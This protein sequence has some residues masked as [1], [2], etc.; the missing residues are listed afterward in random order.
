MTDS[1]KDDTS[2]QESQYPGD[3]RTTEYGKHYPTGTIKIDTFKYPDSGDKGDSRICYPIAAAP[4]LDTYHWRS[5]ES[6]I[7]CNGQCYGG[8]VALASAVDRGNGHCS[9]SMFF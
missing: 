4:D 1:M 9:N 8:E 7:L 3:C 2:Y 5:G 6:G